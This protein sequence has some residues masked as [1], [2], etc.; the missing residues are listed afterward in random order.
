L[1]NPAGTLLKFT[2]LSMP[3]GACAVESIE[4]G[5][6]KLGSDKR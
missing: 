1:V 3:T 4:N 5:E 2:G 6:G